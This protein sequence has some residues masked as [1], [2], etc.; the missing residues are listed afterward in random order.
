MSARNTL[1]LT[2]C[3]LLPLMLLAADAE[4]IAIGSFSEGNLTDWEARSF[5]GETEYSL[6]EED[7]RTVLHAL[8]SA[9]A[10]GLYYEDIEIN[11]AQTPYLNWSWKIGNILSGHDE[12]SRAGDDYPAR[13]YVVFS[14]GMF[15]WQTR[16]IT[17][18]WSSNQPAGSE[19]TS[20]YT[21]NVKMVALRGGDAELGQW[22]GERRDVAADYRRL[23][24]SEPRR[25]VAVA[26][27]TDTDN[28]GEF[29]EAWYGDIWFSSR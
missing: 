3:L 28:T 4:R 14:G 27:M 5:S 17:Y 23:F 26:L 24:G 15:F 21:G 11:L 7:G 13:V 12:R 9:S 22:V 2:A 16:A 8:S 1:S 18:V 20:A 19:W 25:I 10:S 6:Q 29:A